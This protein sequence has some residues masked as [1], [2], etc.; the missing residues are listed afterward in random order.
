MNENKKIRDTREFE[1]LYRD[2]K[3]ARLA[4]SDNVAKSYFRPAIK[5]LLLYDKDGNLTPS[6]MIEQNA[7]NAVVEELKLQGLDRLPTEGEVMERCQA[8][9]ARHNAA[10]YTARR[11]SLG[12]KPI[13]ETKINATVSNPYGD[14]TD[15]ELQVMVDALE[16]YREEQKALRAPE[17][18]VI[19]EIVEGVY[20]NPTEYGF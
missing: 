12:A 10:A 13:D 8:Y 11:D 14:M 15:E 16:K 4:W 3:Y 6:A 5:P 7:Y 19:E 9:Y 1:A 2:P 17:P 18:Q 20:E